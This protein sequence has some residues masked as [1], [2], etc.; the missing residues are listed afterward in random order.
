MNCRKLGRWTVAIVVAALAYQ[1]G[2]PSA[3]GQVVINEIVKD[4]R[5]ATAGT[6]SDEREFIELYNA[7]ETAVNIGGWT[8][9]YWIMNAAATDPAVPPG[10]SSFVDTIP[11]DTMLAPGGF[12]VIG[13]GNVPNVNLNIGTTNLF[14]DLNSVFE[15]R[16]GDRNSGGVIKD[17]VALDIQRGNEYAALA[18]EHA[19]FV[20]QGWWAQEIS[21]DA[22]EPNRT[23]SIG[24]YI[25][26]RNS[27]VNGR[28]FGILPI[29]PGASNNL[30]QVDEHVIANAD[31]MAAGASDTSTYASF[32]LP[33][34][35]APSDS[36]TLGLG[37]RAINPKAIPNS[38][39]GGN[40]FVAWDE[41]GGGNAVYS[42]KYANSF[43]LSAYIETAP[44]NAATATTRIRS[45]ATVYG[46]GTTDTLFVSPDAAGMRGTTFAP[47]GS[48]GIGWYIQ[49]VDRFADADFDGD[50]DVD[51]SD[52][53]TWQRSVGTTVTAPEVVPNESGN[54]DANQAVNAAD[55][56]YWK[57]HHGSGAYTAGTP[58]VG[59]TKTVLM[60]IDFGDGGDSV[61]ADGEWNILKTFD[62]SDAAS[63]WHTLGLDYDPE[64]GNVVAT[65][66][67]QTFNFTTE[68]DLVGNF[69]VGYREDVGGTGA[70]NA[71]VAARLRPATFDMLPSAA[72][73]VPEPASWVAAVGALAGCAARRK[74]RRIRQNA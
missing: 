3:Q 58:P 59:V 67:N 68:E 9:N 46:L 53:L 65:Y 2:R 16:D 74:P 37:G 22:V 20:G 34:A 40:V 5:T 42:E 36:T 11:A 8:M 27:F 10:Y 31:T 35:I 66:D 63:A 17:A 50:S 12:Y 64:T 25:D 47:N 48:K 23:V 21:Y 56:N 52:F 55:L 54:A 72:S 43:K 32:V 33:Y 71:A 13:S 69:Y 26:G 14:E 51:G 15:L 29:S 61:P 57:H 4:V 18:P 28:D 7:G 19:A 45:E 70:A 39:Q 30:P 38:P 60:L 73:G 6:T 49:K 1:A 41:T 44:L 62:L 24:R